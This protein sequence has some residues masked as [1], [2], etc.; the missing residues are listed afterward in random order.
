MAKFEAFQPQAVQ[1]WG[2]GCR[3]GWTIVSQVEP[4]VSKVHMQGL[5]WSTDPKGR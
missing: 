1:S 2:P 3:C 5:G 4:Q